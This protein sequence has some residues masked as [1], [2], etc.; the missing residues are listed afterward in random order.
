MIDRI[1]ELELSGMR[2]GRDQYSSMTHAELA[3]LRP[4]EAEEIIA[5]L[6]DSAEQRSALRFVLRGLDVE[7]A[8]AKVALNRERA[9]KI[10]DQRRSEKECRESLGMTPEEIAEMKMQMKDR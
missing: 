6:H 7:R 2:P 10:R 9:R 8:V 5:Q 3:A 1:D 4:R